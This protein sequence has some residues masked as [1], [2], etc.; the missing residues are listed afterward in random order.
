GNDGSGP[1][2]GQNGGLKG[3]LFKEDLASIPFVQKEHPFKPSS[4]WG[5]IEKPYPTGAWWLNLALEGSTVCAVPQPYG[6]RLSSTNGM[7]ISNPPSY[8][9]VSPKAIQDGC[10]QDLIVGS[11][12]DRA[13]PTIDRYDALSVTVRF[14]EEG[15]EEEEESA[16]SGG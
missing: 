3:P 12:A 5:N 6:A 7:I 2:K 10:G 9:V 1:N 14:D 16:N 4:I 13:N 8:R 15:E 11:T